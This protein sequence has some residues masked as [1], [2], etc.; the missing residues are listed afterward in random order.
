MVN[1]FGHKR[2]GAVIVSLATTGAWTDVHAQSA[3]SNVVSFGWMHIAP[4]TGS[5]P[6][7][8]TSIAGAPTHVEL[9]GSG[10]GVQKADTAEI[11]IEHYLTDNIGLGTAMA[12]P[13]HINFEARGTLERYGVIGK[14]MPF[15]LELTLRYHF[16]TATS[17]FRPYVGLGVNYTFYRDVNLTNNEF[18]TQTFGPGSSVSAKLSNSWN[19]VFELGANYSISR[20]WAVGVALT[21]IPV[22]T[23]FVL[24]ARTAQ[25]IEVVGGA[26]VNIRPLVTFVN[27]SYSF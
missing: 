17:K 24:T 11:Y 20:H 18:G 21:Y 5:A 9:P 6:F 3:G 15:P 2:L 7:A 8:L 19:P 27:A 12:Y 10:G 1:R 25:G 14:A 13:I 22:K 26:K 4:Q 23:N 16:G